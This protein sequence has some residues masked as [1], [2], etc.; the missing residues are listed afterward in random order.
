MLVVG[1]VGVTPGEAV[2][3]VLADREREQAIRIGKR[4]IIEEHFGSEW[5]LKDASG[6]TLV[7]MTPFHRLALAARNSAFRS[8]EMTPKD[9]QSAVKDTEGKLNFRVTLRGGKSDFAR[10]YTPTLLAG[11]QEVKA[12]F[13]QNERTALR[14]EDGQ[15]TARCLYVFPA[16]NV[17]PRATVTLLVRDGD[18]KLVAKFTVDLSTMR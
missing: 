18:E 15:F 16:E 9:V 7:V 13:V 1:L 12:S 2:S 5:R 3:F 17:D 14:G 4:S 11:S 8:Q 6:Q 10:F